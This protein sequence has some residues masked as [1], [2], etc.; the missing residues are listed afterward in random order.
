MWRMNTWLKSTFEI[1]IINNGLRVLWWRLS[2]VNL[3]QAYIGNK[4]AEY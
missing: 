4:Q 1:A 3:Y 2:R